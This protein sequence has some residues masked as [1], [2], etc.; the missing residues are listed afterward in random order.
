MNRKLFTVLG[1][2]LFL[3]CTVAVQAKTREKAKVMPLKAPLEVKIPVNATQAAKLVVDTVFIDNFESDT[4]VWQTEDFFVQDYAYWHIDPY[5]AYGGSG[6]SW[7]CGTDSSMVGWVNPAGGY[8]ACWVQYLYSPTFDL[9]AIS[10]DTVLLNFMHYYSLEGPS[11]GIDWDCLNLWGST[12]GGIN[13]FVMYPDIDRCGADKAYNLAASAAWGYMG[14]APFSTNIPGWGGADKIWKPVCFDL[15]PYKGDSLKLRFSMVSDGAEDDSSAGGG[16]N[17]AWYVDNISVDTFSAGG[18][19][20][21]IFY[22]DVEGGNKGWTPGVK[23]PRINWCRNTNRSNSATHSWYNGDT[24]TYIQA[25]GNSDALISPF[26]NLSQIKNTQPCIASFM[27]WADMPKITAG[28]TRDYDYIEV[29]VSDD[30][31][32]TWDFVNWY[33]GPT[34]PQST[35]TPIENIL[36]AGQIVLTSYTGKI[37]QI[38]IEMNTSADAF[39]HGEGLYLDDF[40]VTGK[41]LDA[42]PEPSTVCLVDNDGGALDIADNSWTKY[43]E[44]SLANLGY[45]YSVVTIGSNKPMFPGYLEQYPLVIWNLG[46]NFDLRAGV[47]YKAL[48]LTDQ[49]CILTYLNSGGNLWMS[50]QYFFFANGTQLD[51]TTHP[52]LW[53]DYLH[54]AP[55]NGWAATTTYQGYGITGDPIGDGLADS[56]LYARL[57]GGGT[58]WTEPN[59][60]YSLNPDSANYPVAGFMMNDD[61]TFNGLRYQ[62]AGLGYNLVYTSFPYEAVSTPEARDTLMARVINWLRPGLNGDYVPPA[63]PQGLILS[64]SYDTVKCLWLANAEADIEGYN[65]YRSIQAGIPTWLKVGT[66]MQPDTVFDD[67]T[68]QAGMTYNYAVTAFDTLM[69]ANESLK[70]LWSRILVSPWKLGLEGQPL[71]VIPVRFSLAQNKPNPFKG[72][73]EIQFALPQPSSVELGVYNVAGQKVAALASG[74]YPAGYHNIR[75][76]GRDGQGRTLSNGVYFY[77]L[78]ARGHDTQER[79]SQTKRLIIVK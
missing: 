18:G 31:G 34:V 9:T 27:A 11:G 14:L 1:L 47:N 52:N 28:Y 19:S 17:G 76:N 45:K 4:I 70:S 59:K 35:W 42:L 71:S 8:G 30:S 26:I 66:V 78:E 74:T 62:D 56:L 54:L 50:G 22:D 55:E 53:M 57:N 10:S 46:S 64:Q 21:T 7:W 67:T 16:Y 6:N 61:S 38:R 23:V 44:S 63:V 20:D 24:L 40:I 2:A 58:N 15:T 72:N 12:D 65:V 69:P 33:P 79:L 41:G 5:N 25:D 36:G 3:F 32:A 68:V 77:R 48:T 29:Y 39:P 51:T 73:T 37:I 43:M 49:E 13:W 60:A 75:W